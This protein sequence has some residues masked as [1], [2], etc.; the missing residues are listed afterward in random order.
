MEDLRITRLVIN[1]VGVF[2]HLDLS[3]KK[4]QFNDKAEI[5]IL[6]GENGTGKT[7]ILEA[8]TYFDFEF[9]KLL[10]QQNKNKERDSLLVRKRRETERQDRNRMDEEEWEM[11][12]FNKMHHMRAGEDKFAIEIHFFKKEL[13]FWQYGGVNHQT[14]SGFL[15]EYYSENYFAAYE[16][17]YNFF[18]Y[19]GHRQLR[20][21]KVE[22]FKNFEFNPITEALTF[23]KKNVNVNLFQWIANNKTRAALSFQKGNNKESDRYLLS[24]QKIETAI[25]EI[26]GRNIE[27]VIDEDSLNVMIKLDNE[28]LHYNTLADGYK[29]V[30]SWLTDL[31][32]RLD[33]MPKEGQENFTLFLDEIDI[34]LHPAAQRRILPVI[35]KLFPKAQIFLTTHSPFIIGSVDDAWIYKFKLDEKGNSVLDGEPFLSEDAKSYRYI[36]EQVFDITKQFGVDV[37]KKLEKFYVMRDEVIKNYSIRNLRELVKYSRELASQS[38]ELQAILGNELR[39]LSR[40]LNKDITL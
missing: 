34:H 2:E 39:Q 17:K 20:D 22:A 18:A 31:I 28:S 30:I 24:I 12:H 23:Y 6:T 25:G 37:E 16:H 19:N 9:N 29:S 27:F 32:F 3:F 8:L 4:K 15:K 7:T 36:L 33:Y 40:I 26:I 21:T 38:N 13:Q 11:M 14:Y 1:N 35:Q 5:H 10:E